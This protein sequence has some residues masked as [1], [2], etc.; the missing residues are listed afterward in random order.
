VPG[1]TLYNLYGPTET[2]V[3]TWYRLPA[4]F[5]GASPIPIGRACPYARVRLDPDGVEGELLVAGDS[6]MA[7]YWNKPEETGKAFVEIEGVQYYRT[8][9]R[10][11]EDPDGNLMFVGRMD[12]QVKRRG[13]RIELGEIEAALCRNPNV[14]EA[15]VVAG[16][17]ITAF[18]RTR[19]PISQAE[20][21]A[22][23]AQTLPAYMLPDRVVFLAAVPKGSRG[24][25]DYTALRQMAPKT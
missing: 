2:N 11:T 14:L 9:D 3:V 16:G 17:N 23:C 19:G 25:I 21:K 12:R 1:A 18:V 7:G 6:L 24:K 15:A 20:V 13:F 5:D 10:V 22:H 4:G 8:G